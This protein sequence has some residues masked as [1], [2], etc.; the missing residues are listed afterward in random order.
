MAGAEIVIDRVRN[1]QRL[2][3][4]DPPLMCR[5]AA[6]T[7]IL[8]HWRVWVDLL[9]TTLTA[10]REDL[11]PAAI[12]RAVTEAWHRYADR[13]ELATSGDRQTFALLQARIRV[14]WLQGER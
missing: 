14:V 12:E 11:L 9:D 10:P 3:V 5:A 7:K 13:G 4:I 6:P 1:G 2:L 8:P